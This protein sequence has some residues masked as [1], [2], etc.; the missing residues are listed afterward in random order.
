MSSEREVLMHRVGTSL[1]NFIQTIETA[2]EAA[3]REQ[4][5]HRTDFSCIGLL[6]RA[7]QP[8]SPK[9][10][11]EA[12]NLRSASGTALIDRL[13]KQGYIRRIPNPDDRRSVLVALNPEQA[14]E[15]L[16]RYQDI[17]QSYRKVTADLTDTDLETIAGFLDKISAMAEMA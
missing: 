2:R 10:I 3:A 6:H 7:G 8:I 17:E 15:I 14:G 13:E 4:N 11:I 1:T 5:L 16:Q 12:L 9:Q